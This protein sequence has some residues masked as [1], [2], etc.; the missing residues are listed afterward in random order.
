TC[1]HRLAKF[2]SIDLLLV[3]HLIVI[4]SSHVRRL[5]EPA[6]KWS[7]ARWRS[8]YISALSFP[9]DAVGGF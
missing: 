3:R 7:A 9:V 5:T 1:S 4:G 6:V 8:S 2:I